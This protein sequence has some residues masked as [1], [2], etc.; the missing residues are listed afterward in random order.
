MRVFLLIGAVQALFFALL[1]FSKKSKNAADKVL[2]F[3]LVALSVNL[4]LPYLAYLNITKYYYLGTLSAF[5][6]PMLSVWLFLYT[7]TLTSKSFNKKW[8]GHFIMLLIVGLAFIP[9]YSQ[10]A[11]EIFQGF[12]DPDSLSF[13]LMIGPLTNFGVFAAYTMKSL[14]TLQKHKKNIRFEFSYTESID[15][16]WIRYLVFSLLALTV[17]FLVLLLLVFITGI[18]LSGFDLTLY[19]YLVAFIFGIGY[20]G[21]KQG[22]IFR[23][24]AE[25]APQQMDGKNDSKINS[26]NNKS[27]DEELMQK[28]NDHM[29]SKKPYL[30]PKLSLY[31]LASSY[32]IPSNALSTHLNRFQQTNFYEYVNYYRVQ[33]AKIRL[34]ENKHKFTILSIAYDCGFN[35]K[36]SFNRIFKNITGFTPSEYVNR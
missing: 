8:L 20:M 12:G 25:Q 16:N 18:S 15:L 4:I 17:V 36:A 22:T 32:G 30:N 10:N 23:Y 2:G 19:L 5:L 7:R 13:A 31:D 1:V 3:W 27:I 24:S 9:Y 6:F 11:E 33:E 28:L 21:F 35:S 29:R 14:T 26:Q 34:K